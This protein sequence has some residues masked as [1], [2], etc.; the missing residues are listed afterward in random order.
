MPLFQYIGDGHTLIQTKKYARE[1][2][3]VAYGE[4]IEIEEGVHQAG[5]II[6][7]GFQL[8]EEGAEAALAA[9]V[10]GVKDAAEVVTNSDLD[11]DGKIADDV[12]APAVEITTEVVD[13]GSAD[14][15]LEVTTEEAP[16]TTDPAA[17]AADLAEVTATA[18]TAEEAPA[19][20]AP[21]AKKK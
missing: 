19:K 9:V 8:V 3:K 17:P 5:R 1:K 11:G 21:P 16:A 18:T 20:A 12:A 2:T 4:I 15:T 7:A 6:M 10:D 13:D 14:I